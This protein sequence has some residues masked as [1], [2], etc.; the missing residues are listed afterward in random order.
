MSASAT[1]IDNL[2]LTTM[3]DVNLNSPV[4]TE[5]FIQVY[6]ISSPN[7]GLMRISGQPGK[8][9]R[10]TYLAAET[11]LED[12]GSGGIVRA[13]YLISGF[14]KDNQAASQLLNPGEANVKLGPEG[15]YY[16]WLGALLDVSKAKPGAYISEFIMEVEGN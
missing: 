16:I 11:L 6:P 10:I 13:N 1:I 4:S 7:A 14:D 8:A 15:H 2:A 5:G 12:G 9:I 3:R